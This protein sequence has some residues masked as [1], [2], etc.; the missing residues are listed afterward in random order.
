MDIQKEL[1]ALADEKTAKFTQKIVNN[2]DKSR[3]LGI[4]TPVLRDFAKKLKK[5]GGAEEFLAALPHKY[6]EEN[7]LHSFLICLE[8]DADRC[9]ELISRFLPHVDNW[10]TCDQLAPKAIAKDMDKLLFHIKE[11]LKSGKTYTVRFGMEMLMTYFLGESFRTEYADMVAEIRSEEYYV[12]MMAAWYFATA[13]AKNRDEI[14]PYFESADALSDWVHAKAISKARESFR[15]SD[16][17]KAYLLTLKR[18][19]K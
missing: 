4:K 14:M 6:F 16:A 12:N 9:F 1:L 13:L 10:A 11:Y 2:V 19:K 8:K 17:D 3:I 7:Q 15:I 18:N 5:E